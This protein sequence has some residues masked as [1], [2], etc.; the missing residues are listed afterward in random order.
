[1]NLPDHPPVAAVLWDCDGVLQHGING[2][3][4]K[5]TSLV[6][7]EMLP[8]LL[9]E[10]QPALRGEEP[11]RAAI[12][13]MIDRLGLRVPV[14]EVLS[15]WDDYELD[16]DALSILRAVRAGGTGC[17]LA[18]NQQDYRRD[19]MRSEYDNLV[20]G[21]FYSCEMGVA[22]PDPAFFRHVVTALALPANALLFVDDSAPN[23]VAARSQGLRA[24]L[25]EPEPVAPQL[26]QLLAEHRVAFAT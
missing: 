22:K 15:V 23:V 12:T 18:T 1:M 11:L 14:P 2:A 5:L 17:Y 26:Q 4:Q 8:T 25:I 16:R 20:D 7:R 3:L 19:R 6:G 24:E 9:A 21:S 10:E 13:R